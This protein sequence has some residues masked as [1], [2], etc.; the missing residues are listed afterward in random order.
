VSGNIT[1]ID[2]FTVSHFTFGEG[3]IPFKT[4]QKKSIQNS[5]LQLMQ[6]NNK[7]LSR[8]KNNWKLWNL[9]VS[10]SKWYFLTL[11]W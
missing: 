11:G 9:T 1:D 7:L 8:F 6:I 5:T 10:K 3:M 4:I 2:I